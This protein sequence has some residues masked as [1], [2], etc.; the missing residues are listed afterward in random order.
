LLL[1]EVYE[2]L[3]SGAGEFLEM[4]QGVVA[5][6]LRFQGIDY[7][8]DE[9]AEAKL[10]SYIRW[11]QEVIAQY[12]GALLQLIIGDKGNYLYATFGA[13]TAHE[14]DPRRAVSAAL[15]LLAQP[16]HLN[17]ISPVQI[18]IGQGM[19]RA[20][21]MAASRAEVWRILGARSILRRLRERRN[22]F[23][24]GSDWL[25]RPAAP[26][27]SPAAPALPSTS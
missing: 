13:P 16:A 24:A 20:G 26:T 22:R 10:D 8:H 14:N 9:Q 27:I 21:A 2:G 15:D 3:T 18:G 6:F 7:D 19:M 23:G 25:C 5:L 12:D 11:V 17:F 4:R 1:P